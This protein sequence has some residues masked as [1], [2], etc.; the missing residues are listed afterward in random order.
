MI[1]ENAH[2]QYL[3]EEVRLDKVF[4]ELLPKLEGKLDPPKACTIHERHTRHK[5][6]LSVLSILISDSD[7]AVA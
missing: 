2:T 5:L 4:K 3:I 1:T 6:S 7:R